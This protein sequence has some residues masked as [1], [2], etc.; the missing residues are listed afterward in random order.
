MKDTLLVLIYTVVL[1]CDGLKNRCVA[2][3]KSFHNS[4]RLFSDK[5]IVKDYG[6]R[7][8]WQMK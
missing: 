4:G 5:L 2:R 1:C 8:F 6:N 7:Y 3:A